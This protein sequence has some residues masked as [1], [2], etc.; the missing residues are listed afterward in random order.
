MSSHSTRNL[1]VLASWNDK[2]GFGF[3]TVDDGNI[4]DERL[5]AHISAFP[6]RDTRPMLGERVS[7]TVEQTK[8]GRLRAHNIRY[9]TPTKAVRPRTRTP[10]LLNYGVLLAFAVAL[11]L[12]TA[13]ETLPLSVAAIYLGASLVSYFAYATDK[14]AAQTKQW[15]VSESILLSVGL[16]GGWPGSII[17]QQ[18]LR[19]K[20]Q[21]ARFRRAFWGTVI[22]NVSVVTIMTTP[23]R[24]R[25]LSLA[26]MLV[27]PE[28]L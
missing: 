8:D 14:R 11:G 13:L 27:A 5:F 4:A 7:F 9:L 1:G 6:L 12:G 19:H 17:A 21:K 24:D 18:R 23:L 22:L 16:L 25:V 3:V 15:R 2:R 20:T 28:S 26:R 10:R